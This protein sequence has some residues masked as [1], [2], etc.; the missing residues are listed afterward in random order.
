MLP[1]GFFLGVGAFG[2]AVG[3]EDEPVAPGYGDLEAIELHLG[4]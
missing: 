2:D 4:P 3:I 1:K